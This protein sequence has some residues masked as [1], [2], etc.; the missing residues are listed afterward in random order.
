MMSA[1]HQPPATCAGSAALRIVNLNIVNLSEL[2]PQWNWISAAFRDS[3]QSWRHVSTQNFEL[4]QWLPRR[5]TFARLLAARQAIKL[6]GVGPSVL[7][8]HGPR[9]TLY[10]ALLAGRRSQDLRHLA[11]S[12]NYTD[13]PTG[14]ARR[15]TARALQSVERFVVFS[16]LEREIYAAYFELPAERFDMLH[17]GVQA[18]DVNLNAPPV[19]DGHYICAL[20]SQG[21]DYKTLLLAMRRLPRLR[22]VIVA[23]P[24]NFANIANLSIP[25]NVTVKTDIPLAQAM[26][27]L[28]HSRFMVLPL[29]GSAV[30]CG[31]VTIVSAMHLGKAVI[32]TGSS[33]LEDY[34][35]PRLTGLTCPAQDDTAWVNAIESLHDDPAMARQ[36]GHA[37]QSFARKHCTEENIVEYMRRFLLINRI[38]E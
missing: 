24:A 21:R 27:I 7:V 32:A 37:G 3:G 2:A 9:P 34:I 20:G 31:H 36:L 38:R 33:G 19:V 4:P 28:T 13:L 6:L 10:G 26:N 16:R 23:T 14:A 5:T 22:L 11:F 18:P 8:S 17:W 15:L 1:V 25:A 30:P 12:F 29:R 35:T